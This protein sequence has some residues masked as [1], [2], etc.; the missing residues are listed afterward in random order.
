M[1]ELGEGASVAT[2]EAGAT[3][4]LV[5]RAVTLKERVVA[6]PVLQIAHIND[7]EGPP[8]EIWPRL[9]TAIR[10]LRVT[11]RCD[12]LLHA[13]DVPLGT[14]AAEG[15]TRVLTHLGVDAIALG[16]HDLADGI[17]ALRARGAARRAPILC[18]NVSDAP[19]S[20]VRPYRWFRR[21][22]VHIAVIGVT[23]PDL[24][25]YVRQ[26]HIGALTFHPPA[27]VLRDL[28]PRLRRRADLVVVL[29][30]CGSGTDRELACQ[31][32]GIDLI[33]SGHDHVLLPPTLVPGTRTW[34]AEAG[35]EGA[36]VGALAVRR[37]GGRL[38]LSGTLLPTAGLTADAD[39]R[40]LLTPAGVD[41]AA[42]AIAGYTATDLRSPD[43]AWETPLGNLTADLLRAYAGTDLAL[44]RCAS[45]NN[46]LPAGPV[47][48]RDLAQLNACGADQVARLRLTGRE[49]VELLEQGAQDGY[50]LLLTSGARV[51]YDVSRQ[52]GRRV[53]A[54]WVG[55]APLDPE[56]R[57]SVA[58]TEVFAR[59]TSVFTTLQGKPHEL[60]PQTI[61]N[62]LE[63]H[64]AA[65]GTIHPRLDGRLVIHGQF[66]QGDLTLPKSGS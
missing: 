63:R 41:P 35:A 12:L 55:E 24:A 25:R 5:Q 44:I 31:V 49:V 8:G 61:E 46:S 51:E 40:A 32:P 52:A 1:R 6:G 10:R 37:S 64:I 14:P 45:V 28:L 18:A 42:E 23:R 34:V 11:G 53:L 60:L 22:G 19:P 20:C 57:Y 38:A 65:E 58:C 27:P 66:P 59:G 33:V 62:L 36:Y 29:S 56:R 3:E 50:F 15:T 39:I 2:D 48:R 16:N 43:D 9:A 13:G 17:A 47:R 30:H 4:E 21:G 26:R 7:T 54:I